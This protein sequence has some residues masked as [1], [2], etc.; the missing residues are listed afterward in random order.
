MKVFSSALVAYAGALAVGLAVEA[1]PIPVVEG[2]PDSFYSVLRR[3]QVYMDAYAPFNSF[4]Y[5]VAASNG[6]YIVTHWDTAAI[7]PP[8]LLDGVNTFPSLEIAE[9]DPDEVAVAALGDNRRSWELKP[10]AVRR[11][12]KQIKR[13]DMQEAKPAE[14]KAAE[15]EFLSLAAEIQQAAGATNSIVTFDAALDALDSVEDPAVSGRLTR[16]LMRI[17]KLLSR[18]ARDWDAALYM[19]PEGD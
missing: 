15:L 13:L 3:V 19:L 16:A 18:Y 9:A 6:V 5:G 14:R 17:D 11:Q 2:D 10:P 8:R 1:A 7:P 12:I 4:E